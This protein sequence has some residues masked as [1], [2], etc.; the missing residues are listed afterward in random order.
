MLDGIAPSQKLLL[1]IYAGTVVRL[2]CEVELIGP[3]RVRS[4]GPG[5]SHSWQLLL[6]YNPKP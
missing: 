4:D 1:S 3:R 6:V 2:L 5:F